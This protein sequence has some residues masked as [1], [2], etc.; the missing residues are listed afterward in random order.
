MYFRQFE[1]GYY[2]LKGDG[3]QK[4]VVDLMTRVKV[5]EK[6]L[7]EASLYDKY[8]VPSGERPED[9][10]FKHFGSS[11]YH[12]VVLLTNNITDVY[13]D[14]PMSEQ[15]FETFIKD[16][17]TNPDGIHHY[18]VTQSSGK[19]TG[20]GPDDY[21]HKIEVNSDA[22]GAQSVS[23]REYEQRLQDEKRSINLLNPAYLTTFIEEFNNLVRN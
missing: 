13:Y 12:W 11:Q 18:E 3:K 15:S 20:S 2:D 10:A 21:S 17:Y 9:T 22:T 1:K 23:N 5:R 6:I 19:T 16:K 7:D 14:W 4:L 8:D